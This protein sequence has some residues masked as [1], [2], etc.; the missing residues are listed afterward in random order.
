MSAMLKLPVTKMHSPV[1]KRFML[2]LLVVETMPNSMIPMTVS[3]SADWE[4]W[5]TS[6]FVEVERRGTSI[7]YRVIN[8]EALRTIFYQ[9][10]PGEAENDG[11]AID[12]VRAFGDS[13]A[14][15]RVSQGVCFLRGWQSVSLNGYTVDLGEATR[16][17]GLFAA[18]LSDLQ[19]DRICLVENLD[20]FLQAEKVL[21]TDWV[22]LHTYGRVGN[23]WLQKIRCQEMLVFSDYDFVGLDE[24]LRV[25][26]AFPEAQ[27]FMPEQYEALWVKYAK[28]LNKRDDSGQIATRRVRESNYPLV[29][30]IREQLLRTGKFLEQQALFI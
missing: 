5:L 8:R 29:V 22:L 12:N 7:S 3:D 23:E 13:K 20:S 19:A 1:F 15:A 10:F 6:G 17:F 26:D 9:K 24:F 21:S 16:H 30:A 28:L 18:V 11:S 14:R 4:N 2:K 27:F 25:R